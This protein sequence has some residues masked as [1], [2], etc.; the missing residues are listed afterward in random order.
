MDT[1]SPPLWKHPIVQRVS[2][3][4]VALLLLV[5]GLNWLPQAPSFEERSPA[6]DEV[7]WLAISHDTFSYFNSGSLSEVNWEDGM[8]KTTYGAMN[9]NLA[10]L[11]FGWQL[12]RQGYDLET[13]RVF[14]ALHPDAAGRMKR[15]KFVHNRLGK[16]ED[17][18]IG[19]RHLDL[20]IMALAGVGIFLVGLVARGYV[21]GVLAWGLF[22]ATPSVHEIAPLIMT[23][24][25]L[26]VTLAAGLLAT[27]LSLRWL[28]QTKSPVWIRVL[29]FA[30]VGAVLALAPSTKLNGAWG[31]LAFAIAFLGIW[32]SG[33]LRGQKIWHVLLCCGT[34]AVLACGLFLLLYP[35]L[36]NDLIAGL[37]YIFARWDKLLGNQTAQFAHLALEGVGDKLSAVWTNG[38]IAVGPSW[39]PGWLIGLGFVVGFL[40]LSWSAVM[41]LRKAERGFVSWTLWCFLAVWVIGT[42]L[43]I[44]IDWTRY[45][46]PVMVF[47]SLLVAVAISILPRLLLA[48]LRNGNTPR[49]ASATAAA[50]AVSLALPSC[51]DAEPETTGQQHPHVLFLS[52]DTLRPDYLG[53]YGYDLDTSPYLDSLLKDAFHFPKTVATVPRTTPALASLLTGAYPHSNG[54]RI[55]GHALRDDV[56]PITEEF[57]RLGYQTAAVVTNQML[58]PERKLSRGFDT[59]SFAKDTRNAAATAKV[60][61]ERIEQ[62][63]FSEPLFLW[64]HFI[65]PHMPYVS[66]PSIAESFDPE[67]NGKYAKQFG[68]FPAPLKPGQKRRQG[69]KGPYPPDLP[70]A[71]AVHQN[72]LTED[73]VSHVRKLYAAD[74]RST[75]DSVRV[76]VERLLELT[77]GNL[78]IVF[79]SDHGESLG[80][81]D[82]YWDHGDYVYNA[83]SRIP[84]AIL[85]PANHPARVSGNYDHWVSIID[86]VP[87]VFDLLDQPI[88]ASMQAQ[89][90]GR[91]LAPAMHGEELPPK[92]V[93]VESGRSHFFELINGRANNNTAGK[94]RA[95]YANDWKL[96]WAPGHAEA[97]LSWQIYN[98]AD[99]PHET[100]NLFRPDHP[101]FTP[102]RRLL[103]AWAELGIGLK[104]DGEISEADRALMQELG[105]IDAED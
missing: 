94:F 36:W 28:T 78:L 16:H 98:L 12:D 9:P 26:I 39:L 50:L 45:Y 1:N 87:T 73:V 54:V 19:L 3:L 56:T 71:V 52:I 17:F 23:D 62:H 7:G 84:L 96:I 85:P 44:P 105:Y 40:Q 34:S 70:K 35:F 104:E 81:H 11:L 74:V 82:F 5:L 14:P 90:D 77:E 43:W 49:V 51:S 65:D 8:Q 68:Q 93:F 95:V 25:L 22:M 53:M 57:K 88:P 6:L 48:Q 20:W 13:P 89:M 37:E 69:G 42:A 99:D 46:L 31:C 97:N 30:A 32:L 102:L 76:L 41:E 91:S 60:A 86:V 61:L 2:P 55:L 64:A 21:C 100:N 38:V 101:Q 92:P 80:E 24:N 58:G 29:V 33:N 47:T 10:K 83:A 15:P 72:P 103:T 66:D 67:Y 4:V 75:D 59:Y 79:T 63:D 27:L 18:M